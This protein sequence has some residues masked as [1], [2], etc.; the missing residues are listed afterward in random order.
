MAE[1]EDCIRCR[2]PFTSHSDPEMSACSVEGCD[3][4][5]YWDSEDDALAHAD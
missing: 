4:G 5:C 1:M 2:H 3:C